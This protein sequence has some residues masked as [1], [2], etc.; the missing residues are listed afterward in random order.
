MTSAFIIAKLALVSQLLHQVPKGRDR[1]YA[2]HEPEIARQA[3][4]GDP[5][6]RRGQVPRRVGC[7]GRADSKQTAAQ[8][9]ELAMAQGWDK[10]TVP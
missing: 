5:P 2:L 10:T 4:R 7:A 8:A 6:E 3:E 1:I 9:R